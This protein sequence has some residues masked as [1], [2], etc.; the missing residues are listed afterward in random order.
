MSL[1]LYISD[2]VNHPILLPAFHLLSRARVHIP[3][4]SC[5][6]TF[7]EFDRYP[8]NNR[9]K[10]H[11]KSISLVQIGCSSESGN[12]KQESVRSNV[13]YVARYPII[14]NQRLLRSQR[15]YVERDRGVE[16][17]CRTPFAFSVCVVSCK[18]FFSSSPSRPIRLIPEIGSE[19]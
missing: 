19:R 10:R 7:H 12:R 13:P 17:R 16:I 14:G 5:R 4:F 3:P 15:F 18:L 11:R 8:V 6:S 1:L 9:R 2:F